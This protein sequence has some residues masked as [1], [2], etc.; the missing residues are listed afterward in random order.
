MWLKKGKVL[1]I[2]YKLCIGTMFLLIISLFFI[3]ILKQQFSINERFSFTVE[4]PTSI[5]EDNKLLVHL[6]SS[7]LEI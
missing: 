5:A 4:E 3:Y 7:K 1:E 2:S 6:S